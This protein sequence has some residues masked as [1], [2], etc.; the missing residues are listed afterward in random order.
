VRLPGDHA[1][2]EE[3]SYGLALFPQWVDL[4]ALRPG[5]D[6]GAWPNGAPPPVETRHPGVSFDPRDPLFAQ[7]G[8]DARTATAG[9]GEAAIARLV[10]HLAAA[11]D[12][13][14]RP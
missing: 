14:L 11:I 10:E 13:H 6:D 12:E 8:E 5:R 2:R 9:R 4:D 1:A 3:A 7:L